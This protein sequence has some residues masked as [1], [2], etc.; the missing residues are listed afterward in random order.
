MAAALWNDEQ[1][2][3]LGHL[4]IIDM[5]VMLPG[6]YLTRIL[7]Q[8]GA[9]VIKVESLPNG[10]PMREPKTTALH[11]WLNQGKRSVAVN[12]KTPKGIELVR[13]IAADADVFVENF[14]EGVMD[15]MG[16][17]YTQISEENPDLL[18]ASLRGFSGRL[19]GNGGHDLN[20][21]ATSGV[22]EWFLDHGPN[23]SCHWGD[24]IGGTLL[25]AIQ[26]LSH[27]SN[28][29]RRGMQLVT[30]MDQGFRAVFL[31]RA[32][33]AVRA[34]TVPMPER[35]SYGEHQVFNGSKPH[36]RYYRC[37]DGGWVAMNA[38]Q[39]KH[40]E[41]FCDLVTQPGWKTRRDDGGLIGDLERL[42]VEKPAS[43]WDT[44]FGG[45]DAC[46]YRVKTWSDHLLETQ[47]R[48]QLTTDPLA[49]AGFAP[50]AQLTPAPTLGQ[51]TFG[52]LNALGLTNKEFSDLVAEGILKS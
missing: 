36:S 8:Y 50:N 12:L 29:D 16:L 52:V 24:L 28:P 14:R 47:A 51:D 20:F 34:E 11:D 27:L 6:P 49:W 32:V 2:K 35:S 33:D 30:Y 7:A 19:S 48:T 25:P 38:I 3:P 26:I 23:Y 43:H 15:S 44:L 41:R 45:Q 10:D 46:V 22:G 31:P 37:Q 5:T 4:R 21:V 18:Y 42:F 9:E 40:W 17:G 13:Q 1:E 39:M